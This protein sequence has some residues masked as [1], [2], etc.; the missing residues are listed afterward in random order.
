M[1][2]E[3]QIKDAIRVIPDFPKKGIEFIDIT[4]IL[5]LPELVKSIIDNI[6]NAMRPL[7]ID[8]V[9]GVESRGFLFGMLL[10]Q[11]LNVPFI[12]LRK[13][14]KLPGNIATYSYNMEYGTASLEVHSDDIPNYAK[15][16]IHDDILA[17]GGTAIA[18][19][20]LVIQSGAKIAA[21]AFIL[22]LESL[23]GAEQLTP[24]SDKIYYLAE[25]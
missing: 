16:L 8:A 9:V 23:N 12:P 13:E 6:V 17:T 10:A 24:Y 15:V 14:G 11:G 21:Y 5:L 2:I 4:P 22:S 25:I 7:G 1:D 3:K 19:S 20:E 18:A